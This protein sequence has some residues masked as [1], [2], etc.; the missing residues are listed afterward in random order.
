MSAALLRMHA[1]LG[2]DARERALLSWNPVGAIELLT[3]LNVGLR[4][5]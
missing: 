3:S 5:G 2:T 4:V 1:F